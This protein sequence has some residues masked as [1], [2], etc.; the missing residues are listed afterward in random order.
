MDSLK[1]IG[2]ALMSAFGGYVAGVPLGMFLVEHLSANRHD[3]S[4]EA[5]MTAAFVIGPVVALVAAVGGVAVYHHLR[6]AS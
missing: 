3:R 1:T 2:I 5:A 6:Q 4:T